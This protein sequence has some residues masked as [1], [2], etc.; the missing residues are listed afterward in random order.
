MKNYW[1]VE[2][3]YFL[4]VVLWRWAETAETYLYLSYPFITP[5]P[6]T[7]QP[8]MWHSKEPVLNLSGNPNLM[9]IPCDCKKLLPQ[10]D[11][12]NTLY[13]LPQIHCL[14]VVCSR[15]ESWQCDERASWLL[16]SWRGPKHLRIKKWKSNPQKEW[17]NVC[18]SEKGQVA[19]I[20]RELLQCNHKKTKTQFKKGQR[21]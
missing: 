21:I 16:Q 15:G 8:E 5:S 12:H 11:T 18:K 4:S 19:I 9:T 14:S 10:P 1:Q 17:E 2:E 7:R 3:V 20:P 13:V 6:N